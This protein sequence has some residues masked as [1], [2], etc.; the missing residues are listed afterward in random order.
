M[1]RSCGGKGFGEE[2][3]RGGWLLRKAGCWKRRLARCMIRARDMHP[4]CT[5]KYI[6]SLLPND[7]NDVYERRV[8][9]SSSS[10]E[11]D[12]FSLGVEQE[13]R[14]TENIAILVVHLAVSRDRRASMQ[15]VPARGYRYVLRAAQHKYRFLSFYAYVAA[16]APGLQG[17]HVHC[18]KL[19]V[20]KFGSKSSRQL[21]PR[22]RRPS[23]SSQAK[24]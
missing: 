18:P 1:W 21:F 23:P 17:M 13:L 2:R 4:V 14:N 3:G 7:T 19:L 5:S 11:S 20:A 6:L 9:T 22:S 8:R 15:T 16:C 10:S 24:V 12:W